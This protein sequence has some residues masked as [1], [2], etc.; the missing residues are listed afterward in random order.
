MPTL[1]NRT[2][3]PPKVFTVSATTRRHS[4]SRAR[5]AS[6]SKPSPVSSATACL[7]AVASI[8]A[9]HP[10]PLARE[11][12]RRSP[13]HTLRS[14]GH[15]DNFAVEGAHAWRVYALLF[16]SDGPFAAR[17]RCRS[18]ASRGGAAAALRRGSAEQR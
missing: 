2:S 7:P 4:A 9:I 8:S 5:S 17:R 11:L 10:R 18:T 12:E 14:T 3:T 13:T 1:L 15:D 16:G 6:T